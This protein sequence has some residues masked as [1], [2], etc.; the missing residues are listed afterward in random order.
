MSTNNDHLVRWEFSE[1]IL[2]ITFT[3]GVPLAHWQ[4]TGSG[5][6]TSCY[7]FQ[8]MKWQE[9]SNFL[10]ELYCTCQDTSS[11]AV[12]VLQFR[13]H[14]HQTSSSPLHSC[15]KMW[16]VNFSTSRLWQTRPLL[17]CELCGVNSSWPQTAI[18][19]GSSDAPFSSHVIW[20]S[21]LLHPSIR[22]HFSKQFLEGMGLKADL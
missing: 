20:L 12:S 18:H 16:T 15:L 19:A 9:N 14:W 11:K 7:F 4:V 13:L 21:K 17:N 22:L 2:L 8:R 10:R 1:L 3:S 5:N 6:R